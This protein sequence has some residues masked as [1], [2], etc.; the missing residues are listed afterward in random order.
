MVLQP[1][2]L[3]CSIIIVDMASTSTAVSIESFIRVRTELTSVNS[4]TTNKGMNKKESVDEDE[5]EN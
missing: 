5:D 1:T 2:S 4:G 3:S